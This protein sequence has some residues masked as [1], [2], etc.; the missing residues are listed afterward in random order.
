MAKGT[1]AARVGWSLAYAAVLWLA[2]WLVFAVIWESSG[3]AKLGRDAYGPGTTPFARKVKFFDLM[4]ALT[5]ALGIAAAGYIFGYFGVKKLRKNHL[6]LWP[7]VFGS[8][9]AVALLAYI[10]ITFKD[11]PRPDIALIVLF[12]YML[13]TLA[14]GAWLSKTFEAGS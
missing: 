3:W 2:A 10:G 14:I 11:S 7:D 5:T 8:V 4:Q 12:G 1:I 6:K 13:P 9:L